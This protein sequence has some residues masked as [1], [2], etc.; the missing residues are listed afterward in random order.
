MALGAYLALGFVWVTAWNTV[1]RFSDHTV[2]PEMT[3][4]TNVFALAAEQCA[5]VFGIKVL[6]KGGRSGDVG[7]QDRDEAALFSHARAIVR[8]PEASVSA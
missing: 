2:L 5:E 6:A 7:E 8:E 3:Q 1:L 4:P